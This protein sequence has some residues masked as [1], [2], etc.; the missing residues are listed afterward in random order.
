MRKLKRCDA[1]DAYDLLTPRERGDG[2][3]EL[4]LYA[5]RKGTLSK[6]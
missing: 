2:I 6:P 1:E 4:T 5:V 3:P